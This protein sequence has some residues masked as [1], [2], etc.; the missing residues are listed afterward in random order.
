[1]T[2]SLPRLEQE[3]FFIAPIGEEGSDVRRRSNLVLKYI[4]KPA[5]AELGLTA[6]RGD[7]LDSPGQ[8]TLRIIDHILH[9]NTAVADLTGRNP[10]VFYEL[11]VRHTARLPT[12]LIVAKSDPPLPFDIQQMNTI[13]FDHTDLESADYC[14]QSVATHLRAALG[15]ALDSPITASIDL[16]S[17][18]AGNRVERKLGELFQDLAKSLQ[19]NAASTEMIAEVVAKANLPRGSQ[20]ERTVG[21]VLEEVAG[22]AVQGV[23]ESSFVEINPTPLAGRPSRPSRPRLLT[24]ENYPTVSD[25]LDAVWSDLSKGFRL[26]PFKY[27]SAWILRDA[28]TGAYLRHMGRTWAADRGQ[29]R[30]ERSLASVGIHPGMRLEAVRLDES[31]EERDPTAR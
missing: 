18:E 4:V 2:N 13:R 28:R 21:A 31:T 12:A 17:L 30:D 20:T 1:M 6:V 19:S 22:R 15:G 29:A 27:G 16:R 10:N 25:F 3:C 8:I 5:A 14:R 23:R 24:Y 7:E 26:P 11:A 9:A